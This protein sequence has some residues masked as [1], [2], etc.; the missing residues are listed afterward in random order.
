MRPPVEVAVQQL[1]PRTID[2]LT[3][4]V[5]QTESSRQV[6]VVA[7]VS[8]F[9]ERIV[10]REGRMVREGEVLFEMDKKPFE[11][12]LEIAQGELQASMARLATA[13][14]NLDRT[15]PLAAAD[16]L[17]Q[18]D[19]D[20]AIGDYKGAEAAV[21]SARASIKRAEL[22]L[23]YAT[24]RSPV[25]GMAGEAVQREG[26]FLNAQAQSANLAYVAQVDP[27]WVNFSVSQNEATRRDERIRAGRYVAP[28]EDRYVVE[29]VLSDGRVFPHTGELDFADPSYDRRTGTFTV[30]AAVPNPDLVLRPGMFVTA[31]L[32]GATRPDAVVVPQRAVIKSPDGHIVWLV[33]AQGVAEPRPVVAGDWLGDDWIIEQGLQGDEVIIVDGVQ[34]LAPGAPVKPVPVGPSA[35]QTG[36]R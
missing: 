11:A 15:K 14:A 3:S 27:I 22:N 5:A 8:G 32:K 26:A 6:E 4:R 24:I 10:Y 7:R 25:T 23:G 28:P 1:Q 21:F 19:L 20:R 34:R 16:A 13:K 36:S 31:I 29:I 33:N 2:V 12:D 17:S 35:P 9:L 18:S 30:R